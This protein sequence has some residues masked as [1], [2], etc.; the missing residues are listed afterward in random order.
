MF[1]I[2][3]VHSL[4]SP[5]MPTERTPLSRAALSGLLLVMLGCC[6]TAQAQDGE[7]PSLVLVRGGLTGVVQQAWGQ[8][9]PAG[10]DTTIRG[11]VDIERS[12]V[13]LDAD[14]FTHIRFGRGASLSNRLPNTFTSDVN[15]VAF[16]HH[17]APD[18]FQVLL[19]Q[20]WL[21]F[22]RPLNGL[23]STDNPAMVSLTI[24]KMDPTVFFDTNF[25]SDEES[26]YFLN[27]VFVHN[28]LLDSGGDVGA[29]FYGF[30]PGLRLAITP[31]PAGEQR[32]TWS[33]GFFGSGN[34]PTFNGSRRRPFSIAQWQYE[35][36]DSASP[37]ARFEVYVWQNPSVPNMVTGVLE[38]HQ[39]VGLSFH[40]ALSPNWTLI[41]RA[42]QTVKGTVRFDQVL[43]TGI[44][45]A[46]A[47]WGRPKDHAGFSL[48]GLR[49][50]ADYVSQ[51]LG[52]GTEVNAE[53]YYAWH[54]LDSLQVSPH[55]QWVHRPAA[56]AAQP[57]IVVA[58]LR[59]KWS[60]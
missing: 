13:S 39:G 5:T 25:K 34:G 42:G 30:S 52:Q 49:A 57:D 3:Q 15:S 11:D 29:D 26:E 20:S 21:K 35:V 36:G 51:G 23:G 47:W 37:Q 24:G 28:P 2:I 55:I 44:Q 1:T 8:A 32:S 38:R 6:L 59:T 12:L 58:G 9:D 54:V 31:N 18:E 53:L 48:G 7:Q 46:G 19:A 22:D 16:G 33:L 45:S 17:N 27:N 10:T 4:I 41:G 40:Q 60:F 43:T 14:W 56:Q 50:S